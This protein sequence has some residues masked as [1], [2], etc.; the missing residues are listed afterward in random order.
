MTI[1][2]R[3]FLASSVATMA[4]PTLGQAGQQQLT[5]SQF[6]AQILPAGNPKTPVMG[7]NGSSPGPELR[8]KQGQ[9]VNVLFQ[10]R[11][12]EGSA[13]HWHGIRLQNSMDGVPILT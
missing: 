4:M 6:S 5:A 9:A 13:V 10:N 12:D 11:L 8:V 1:S 7:F 3:T 2:R